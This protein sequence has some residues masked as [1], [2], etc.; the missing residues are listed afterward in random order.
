MYNS[1]QDL[2]GVIDQ[3]AKGEPVADFNDNVHEHVARSR[4]VFDNYKTLNHWQQQ[5]LDVEALQFSM[6]LVRAKSC[7]VE[8]SLII[9]KS[10]F[11][12]IKQYCSNLG[13]HPAAYFKALYLLMLHYYC[14]PQSDFYFNEIVGGRSK[15]FRHTFGCF[16]QTL[17]TIVPNDLLAN[18]NT[19]DDVIAFLQS[20]KMSARRYDKISQLAQ[21]RILPRGEQDFLYN[22]YNFI[23]EVT[24][25]EETVT[26]LPHPQIQDGPVQFIAQEYDTQI[27]LQ[28][29]FNDGTFTSLAFLTRLQHLSQQVLRGAASLNTL[30]FLLPG[31]AQDLEEIPIT[32]CKNVIGSEG[33][34]RALSTIVDNIIA[35]CEV[36]PR[37]V[38]VKYAGTGIC[39]AD[40]DKQSRQWAGFLKNRGVNKG[41]RVVVVLKPGLTLYPVL[42][43]VLRIG[44]V[45]VPVD[46]SYPT[47]RINYIVEDSDASLIVT[48]SGIDFR[49]SEAAKKCS[50][51]DKVVVIDTVI[52]EMQ[53]F[54]SFD[55]SAYHPTPE[56]LMYVIYT[57]GSTGK[58]K[59]A[60]VYHR[61]VNNL[62]RWYIDSLN[63]TNN[64][65]F[66]LMSSVAFDLTQ[67]NPWAVFCSGAR[68]VIPEM[69]QY[70]PDVIANTLAS[71]SITWLNCAPSTFY[72]LVE[73]G[74]LRGY[75]FKTLRHVV[76]GG[77]S[78]RL[79][80]IDQ[81]LRTDHGNVTLM[82]S[83]GPTEC[84][85]V[86]ASY[87][88]SPSCSSGAGDG[89]VDLPIGRA[90][91]NVELYIVDE[92]N[93]RLAP[94][95][96]GELCVAGDAVGAGYLSNA[97]LTDVSF[98]NNP[99]GGGLLYKTGDL[100]RLLPAT[101][102]ISYVGRKDFQVKVRGLRIELGEIEFA[103]RQLDTVLDSLALVDGDSII[104]YALLDPSPS[105][106]D[107]TTIVASLRRSLPD[108][109]VPSHIVILDKW[110]LTPNG[111]VD[112][113]K[114]PQ[115]VTQSG[116]NY[117]APK[118][119]T[120]IRLANIWCDVLNIEKVGV[121]DNFFDLGGHSLL[122]ARVI[123]KLRKE[124]SVE[125]SLRVLFE[126]RTVSDISR[127]IDRLSWAVQSQTHGDSFGEL[128]ASKQEVGGFDEVGSFDDPGSVSSSV[129]SS[130][131]GSD[132]NS[133]GETEEGFL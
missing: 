17:P 25:N 62:L 56:S 99:F 27:L 112:R 94:G 104:A 6:P 63:I 91:P 88:Y 4:K 84:T 61:G 16:F 41:D 119:D 59:G 110:P 126:M 46:T 133:D 5:C 60:G 120:E 75:P 78:I 129:S 85:D 77:E 65:A 71:E 30:D 19:F 9:D 10:E 64:D 109:M 14:R 39:Y 89:S 92:C 74:D 70:D 68:L 117:V 54:S 111:K 26:L 47:E 12:E 96:V 55:S 29:V 1:F 106:I 122:A 33:E 48:E 3:L 13:V 115:P 80:T 118:T 50:Y 58:P 38:A 113:K 53:Q 108:F 101:G 95:L 105:S 35:Q 114:L 66:L 100:A 90:I 32:E 103:I 127:Y 116:Q 72:P 15:Q 42:L 130:V 20:Y 69:D 86:V 57:S 79:P 11:A 124:F 21:R 125:I 128:D 81:W 18:N 121:F 93:R 131:S 37:T 73:E 40:L 22:Y 8:E 132:P 7:R 52:E 34:D 102:Q 97:K 36:S 76:L 44:A 23:A 107:A 98:I 82:N 43:G 2:F 51:A 67:K 24:Q 28:F 45:Y 87:S 123:S 49:D 31:E 83:Y